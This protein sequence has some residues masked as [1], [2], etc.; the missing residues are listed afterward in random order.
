[1]AWRPCGSAD[2]LL[3]LRDRRR[4]IV[5]FLLDLCL[6][7]GMRDGFAHGCDCWIYVWMEGCEMGL[8]MVVIIGFMFGWRDARWVCPWLCFICFGR[9]S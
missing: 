4:S 5:V 6:D 8:P 7:G 1:M 3:A 2:K 9:L